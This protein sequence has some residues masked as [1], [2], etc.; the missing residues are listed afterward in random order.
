[1]NY[2]APKRQ[3]RQSARAQAAEA[4]ANRIVDAFALQLRERWFDEIRLEDVARHAG[5]T[6]QTVIRRFGSKEGLLEATHERLGNEIRQRRVVAPG[7]AKGAVASIVED[8][9]TVGDLVVRSLA[10]EDRYPAVKAMT[11][12][13][14]ASH[15]EWISRAFQPWLEPLSSEERRKAADALVVAGDVY[16]WK[17][18]RRDMKR[19]LA[20]YRALLERLCAAAVGVPRAQIFETSDKKGRKW[21]PNPPS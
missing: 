16:V 12:I 18:I 19:P 13:G 11:D 8:Y 7:D 15:R 5:V 1:M 21:T 10:Q 6:V 20:E 2:A 3:Y 9:E 4:T 17:L 14:R